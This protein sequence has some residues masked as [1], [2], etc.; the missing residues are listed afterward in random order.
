M[1]ITSGSSVGTALRR[2]RL[3]MPMSQSNLAKMINVS[4]ST[5]NRVEHNSA[6]FD[7]D[8]VALMPPVIGS[9]VV[10]ALKRET[11]NIRITIRRNSRA[12]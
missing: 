12:A 9:A 3:G 11:D 5:L 6:G 10:A 8:W 2:A 1:K 7:T 4:A